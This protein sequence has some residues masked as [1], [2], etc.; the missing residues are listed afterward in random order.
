L[1]SAIQARHNSHYI[2]NLLGLWQIYGNI[3]SAFWRSCF[4]NCY[5]PRF[6]QESRPGKD[7]SSNRQGSGKS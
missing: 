2:A 1:N 3:W 4:L 7:L 5:S 6:G